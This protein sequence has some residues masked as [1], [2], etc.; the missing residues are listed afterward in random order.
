MAEI[1]PD[2]AA[3]DLIAAHGA[4]EVARAALADAHRILS[5]LVVAPGLDGDADRARGFLEAAHS[6]IEWAECC[7]AEHVG[8]A[9]Q[10]EGGE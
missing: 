5:R 9:L 6:R 4:L 2:A 1:N 8:R 3:A 7:L 10:R